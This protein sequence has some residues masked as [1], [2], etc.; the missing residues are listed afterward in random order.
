MLDIGQNKYQWGQKVI[1]MIDLLNDGSYPEVDSEALLVSR[2]TQGEI[3]QT[4]IHEESNTAIYLVEFPGN[5]VVGCLEDEI[6]IYSS[7]LG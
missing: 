6:S 3:V 4:G 1:A 2:G 7:P 5:K